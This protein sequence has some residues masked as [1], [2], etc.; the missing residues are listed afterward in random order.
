MTNVH[1]NDSWVY[2]LNQD[3][4]LFVLSAVFSKKYILFSV[5][6]S[7][8]FCFALVYSIFS[9][10]AGRNPLNWCGGPLVDY[11]L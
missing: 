5:M 7:D 3:L 1:A 11:D 8:L 10:N 9:L 2:P 4:S 6:Y